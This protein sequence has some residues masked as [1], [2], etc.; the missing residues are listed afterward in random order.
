[1]K[2]P[3]RLGHARPC[4]IPSFATICRSPPLSK[5]VSGSRLGELRFDRGQPLLLPSRQKRGIFAR[6]HDEDGAEAVP[7]LRWQLRHPQ[8]SA[9]RRRSPS[10]LPTTAA[11]C[12]SKSCAR[13]AECRATA[14]RRAT[15]S[16]RRAVDH[17]LELQSF[18]R[19]GGDPQGKGLL[20]RSGLPG[21]HDQ[22]TIRCSDVAP[23]AAD[24]GIERSKVT[25]RPPCSTA[26]ARR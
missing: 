22:T 20:E 13:P 2:H 23:G 12:C 5:R 19:A 9:G 14:R 11:G 1:M 18:R 24:S 10:S 16:R 21:T 6:E 26:S 3:R 4:F 17:P 8:G 15:W 7:R 25:N